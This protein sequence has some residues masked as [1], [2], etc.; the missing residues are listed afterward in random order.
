MSAQNLFTLQIGAALVLFFFAQ[1][2]FFSKCDG[3]F[4][5]TKPDEPNATQNEEKRMVNMRIARSGDASEDD[6]ADHDEHEDD[7][8]DNDEDEDDDDDN[9]DKESIW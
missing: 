9:D 3:M 8:D 7:D 4:A 6:D 5:E 1:A 2:L